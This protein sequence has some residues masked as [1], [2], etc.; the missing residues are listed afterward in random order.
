MNAAD[1]ANLKL[2]M[3]ALMAALT[4]DSSDDD[5][6]AVRSHWGLYKRLV[7]EAA[8][9]P[10][11]AKRILAEV[12]TDHAWANFREVRQ[13]RL[14]RSET[15]REKRRS[16]NHDLYVATLKARRSTP[17]YKAGAAA[18]RREQRA[19]RRDPM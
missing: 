6:K 1:F 9:E 16:Y 19:L 4:R 17:D 8:T 7:T 15:F 2:A 11:E 3:L 13:W 14:R 10:G 12:F 5:F 18:R